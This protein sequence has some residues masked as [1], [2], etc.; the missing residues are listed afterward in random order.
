ML[1]TCQ[2]DALTACNQNDKGIIRM[3]CGSGKTMVEIELCLQ[4]KISCLVAPRNALLKQHISEFKKKVSY[5]DKNTDEFEYSFSTKTFQLI[6]INCESDFTKYDKSSKSVCFIINNCSL[7]ALPVVPDILIVDEA[8]T[9]KLAVLKCKKL[10]N[11]KRKYFFTATPQDMTDTSF[12]G[13]VINTY[14]YLQA[15]NESYVTHFKIVP[16]WKKENF[17]I[18]LQEKMNQRK[19]TH[20]IHFYETVNESSSNNLALLDV[21]MKKLKNGMKITD[22]TTDRDS[23]FKKFKEKGGHLLSCKTISYGIDIPECDS[24]FL[25]YIGNSIPDTVQK[26]MRAIRLNKLKKDKIAYIFVLMD[27][28]E[29]EQEFDPDGVDITS[30]VKELQQQLVFK[31]SGILKKGLDLD[32]LRDYHPYNIKK[33]I[34]KLKEEKEE[35]LEELENESESESENESEES[36][37][38]KSDNENEE[39]SSSSIKDRVQEID[40]EIEKLEED[41]LVHQET[42]K[43]SSFSD[44]FDDYQLQTWYVNG[45]I[46]SKISYNKNM[47]QKNFEKLKK[48]IKINKKY[49]SSNKDKIEASL[50]S[51]CTTQRGRYKGVNN[52]SLIT[53]SQIQSLETLPD[54]VWNQDINGKWNLDLQ[55]L[56]DFIYKNK[57]FPSKDEVFLF[58]WCGTQR[59]NYKGIGNQKGL[60]DEQI[61]NL[62]KIPGWY[63]DSDEVWQEKAN[64]VKIFIEKYEKL[65]SQTSSNKIEKSFGHW[66]TVQRRSYI[67]KTLEKE[68]I[69]FLESINGWLWDTSDFIGSINKIKE[70]I[71]KNNRLPKEKRKAASINDK[72][73]NQLNAWC[74][75][76]R[77]KYKMKKLSDDEIKTI[78]SINGWFWKQN[79]DEEWQKKADDTYNYVL[80]NKILPKENVLNRWCQTQRSRYKGI[81]PR[82]AKLTSVQIEF[83]ENIPGWFW[84]SGVPIKKST[85]KAKNQ[86]TEETIEDK[87]KDLSLEEIKALYIKE[88]FKSSSNYQAP[89]P[90]SKEQINKLFSENINK[91]IE[92]DIIVLDDI[93]FNSSKAVKNIV[94]KVKE[95]IVPNNSKQNEE[96]SNN[97][98]F[99]GCVKKCSL[100]ELLDTYIENQKPIKAIYADL[101]G[102][103]STEIS[104]LEQIKKCNLTKGCVVGFTVS[105]RSNTGADYTNEYATK[106]LN[107]MYKTF[108]NSE[109]LVSE[110]GVYVYG[111]K[112]RMATCVFKCK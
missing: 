23:I 68:K 58:N 109:N 83:L 3:C 41:N 66:S 9:H 60:T 1:R 81:L 100:Q 19:L 56:N 85:V 64:N 10:K 102:S 77:Q 88:K 26:M 24:V 71:I 87:I 14:D 74:G 8:H 6:T 51:W 35:L 31:I 27:I 98:T 2:K 11:V 15:Y 91:K 30:T 52:R 54:W 28:P 70:F 111:E 82:H 110:S 61:E 105:A 34:N 25:S 32:V 107:V 17:H 112:V 18:E 43:K 73:E 86:T 104:V 46:K 16:I 62:E 69:I 37:E 4:E 79:L 55:K 50:A 21:P 39:K 5:K 40:E 7:N 57:K 94:K 90:I 99:G 65:P 93:Q 89:N 29:P 95:I 76:I 44:F 101:M 12:Y 92:G 45:E 48:F 49:P 20:C 36:E 103:L 22:K 38:S 63:W 42:I 96:M 84:I 97:E 78:E 47:W 59:K 106:L 108:N 33:T 72:E 67:K 75:T 53:E 80:Q 13:E